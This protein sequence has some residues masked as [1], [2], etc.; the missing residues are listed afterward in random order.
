MSEIKFESL[1]FRVIMSIGLSITPL[2]GC[3]TYKVFEDMYCLTSPNMFE[4][5]TLLGTTI[6]MVVQIVLIIASQDIQGVKKY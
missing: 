5:S 4:F 1:K 6:L 3:V 2:I